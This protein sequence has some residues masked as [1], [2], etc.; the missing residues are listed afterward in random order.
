MNS[1]KID[2]A[3]KVIEDLSGE[4]AKAQY[5]WI[6]PGKRLSARHKAPFPD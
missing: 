3:V 6:L 4:M 2:P 1:G 5:V